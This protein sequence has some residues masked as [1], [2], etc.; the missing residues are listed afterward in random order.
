MARRVG[1]TGGAIGG[2]LRIVLAKGFARI[3]WQNLV[4]FGVLAF[5]LI[6]LDA[7][8][9]TSRNVKVQIKC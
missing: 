1:D 5:Q 6:S 2:G 4:N 8:R 9:D 7:A 3:H